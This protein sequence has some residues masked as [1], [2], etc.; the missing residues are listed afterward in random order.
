MRF[1]LDKNRGRRTQ[2]LIRRAGHDVETVWQESL[3]RAPD[4]DLYDICR[5]ERRCL[6]TLD[7]DFADVVRFPP[8]G[9]GGIV[10]IRP[11]RNPSLPLLEGLMHQLL[12]ALDAMPI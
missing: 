6:V 5:A 7:L 1:R 11:P 2:S 3:Q 9:T 8:D 10:V 4:Q 12:Q